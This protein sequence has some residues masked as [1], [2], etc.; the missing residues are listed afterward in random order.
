MLCNLKRTVKVVAQDQLLL[1][2]GESGQVIATKW[3]IVLCITVHLH[4]AYL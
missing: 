2:N 3:Y 4:V 1:E